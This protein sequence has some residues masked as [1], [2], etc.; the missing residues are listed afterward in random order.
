MMALPACSPEGE[1]VRESLVK[2]LPLN[3]QQKLNLEKLVDTFLPESDTKGAVSLNVHQFL[4]KLLANC[5]PEDQQ[6]SF[7]KG[8]DMLENIAEQIYT[9][10]FSS[11]GNME[12]EAVLM[13]FDDENFPEGKE[14]FDF[15]K[16]QVIL[17]FTSSEYFLTNFT[18]YE[19]IP[20]D[21]DGCVDVPE[22]PYKI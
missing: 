2:S 12:R 4:D 1:V 3:P 10:S 11:L 17:A 8:L 18:N 20:G 9:S 16:E 5:F 21:Y 14:F 6:A 15:A 19:M 13:E 7:V 22:V